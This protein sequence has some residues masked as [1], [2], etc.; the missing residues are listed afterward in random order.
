M[1]IEKTQLSTI[2]QFWGNNTRNLGI[3]K[4]ERFELGQCSQRCRNGARDRC[5]SNTKE[6][7]VIAA[8]QLRGQVSRQTDIA[9]KAQTLQIKQLTDLRRQNTREVIILQVKAKERGT[10]KKRRRDTTMEGIR[11]EVKFKEGGKQG[12]RRWDRTCEEIITK[13]EDLEVGKIREGGR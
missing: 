8:T 10:I 6:G 9:T 4:R 7:K 1:E 13:V 2:T 5:I 11:G 12:E 3:V